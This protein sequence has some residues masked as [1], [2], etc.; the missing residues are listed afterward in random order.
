MIDDGGQSG[1]E[2]GNEGEKEAEEKTIIVPNTGAGMKDMSA[3]QISLATVGIVA[4]ILT[5]VF[6]IILKNKFKNNS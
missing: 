4:S 2:P 6:G 1:D 5:V 3:A